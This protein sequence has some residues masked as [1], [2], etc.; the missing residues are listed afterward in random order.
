MKLVVELVI[1]LKDE[2]VSFIGKGFLFDLFI[3]NIKCLE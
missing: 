1:E 3:D 2:N